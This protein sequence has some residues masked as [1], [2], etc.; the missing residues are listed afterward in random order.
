[1]SAA[2]APVPLCADDPPPHADDA[3]IDALRKKKAAEGKANR[4]QSFKEE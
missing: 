3:L 1:M 4:M 2:S